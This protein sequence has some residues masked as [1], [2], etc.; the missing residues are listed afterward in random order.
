MDI[1][2]RA[3][4]QCAIN[5]DGPSLNEQTAGTGSPSTS[6]AESKRL[7]RDLFATSESV[8]QVSLEDVEKLYLSL[9]ERSNSQHTLLVMYAPWCSHCKEVE[10]EVERLAK[11]LADQSS[12]VAV[13]ALNCDASAARYFAKNV[14]GQKY[15]PAF[16]V[17]PKGSKTYYKYK[18]RNRDANSLLSFLNMVCNQQDDVVWS[19]Q[20]DSSTAAGGTA[21]SAAAGPSVA[22]A[23]GTKWALPLPVQLPGG[24]KEV[25][26]LPL[27]GA[28]VLIAALVA[29]TRTPQPTAAAAGGGAL[30]T[31][32]RTQQLSAQIDSSLRRMAGLMLRLMRARVGLAIADVPDEVPPPTS[33]NGSAAVAAP[34]APAAALPA[35]PAAAAAIKPDGGAGGRPNG[36]FGPGGGSSGAPVT[37]RRGA[38][39]AAAVAVA[40]PAPLHELQEQEQELDV[41]YQVLPPRHPDVAAPRQQGGATAA[42]ASR[43]AQPSSWA[44]VVLRPEAR[45]GTADAVPPGGASPSHTAL[46][47]DGTLMAA[48][49]AAASTSAA[50]QTLDLPSLPVHPNSATANQSQLPAQLP[51]QLVAETPTVPAWSG[52]LPDPR[53][54]PLP[55]QGLEST[56]TRETVRVKG[57]S[58]EQLLQIL[59]QEGDDVGKALDRLM[60]QEQVVLQVEVLGDSPQG[61]RA[62]GA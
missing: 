41:E 44:E 22:A 24:V 38:T 48:A 23:A 1:A 9:C 50:H 43:L 49:A 11:G 31:P 46:P 29:L 55:G 33:S 61:P 36:S 51:S 32:T 2:E 30:S 60:A 21:R 13:V 53:S 28:A 4:E 6:S 62:P 35:A 37:I 17:F 42:A 27:A 16:C 26:V 20:P 5:T 54:S 57:M 14:L 19:L 39:V 52:G 8:Q 47:S 3:A 45:T 12:G 25:G 58:A 10:P 7:P 56:L 59:D 34:P 15:L 40:V 18:G